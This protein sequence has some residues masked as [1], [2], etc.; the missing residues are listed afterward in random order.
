MASALKKMRE[1]DDKFERF[2]QI[3]RREDGKFYLQLSDSWKYRTFAL[4]MFGKTAYWILTFPTAKHKKWMSIAFVIAATLW[5]Q[6]KAMAAHR[7]AVNRRK[8]KDERKRVGDAK[9][10]LA[11]KLATADKDVLEKREDILKLSLSELS[12]ALKSG[13]YS[14]VEVLHAYQAKAMDCTSQVNCVIEPVNEAEEWAKQLEKDEE[15]RGLLY[16]I[17]VSIKENI[18]IKGYTS[19]LGLS[20]NIGKPANNDSALVQALKQQGAVPFVRTNVPQL[21]LSF[22]CSNP[23]YGE[24]VNPVNPDKVPG[25]SSGGE[26]ALVKMNGTPLGFG[27]DILGSARIPAHMSGVCGF[28][29]TQ[30]SGCPGLFSKDIDSIALGM[31]ALL[32]PEMFKYDKTAVPIPFREQ[33]YNGDKKLRIGY[34]DTDKLILPTTPCRRAVAIAKN[35]LEKAGH[36]LIPFDPPSPS[37]TSYVNHPTFSV[38][39]KGSFADDCQTLKTFL[40][41]EDVDPHVAVQLQAFFLPGFLKNLLSFLIRWW[42]YINEYLKAWNESELDVLICPAFAIPACTSQQSGRLAM[43]ASYSSLFNMLDFPAGCVPV[44]TVTE[45]DEEDMKTYPTNDIFDWLIKK[46]FWI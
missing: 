22:V 21:L 3:G 36:T 41:D 10:A 25:G 17:P 5:L 23:I 4:E 12:G 26:A 27:T 2:F 35:A 40:K 9:L 33:I 19:T 1:W 32:V 37:T 18:N 31:R 38:T 14:P 15:R 20:K 30:L 28:K 16:G 7:R 34:Y 42:A 46:V 44:T 11:N 29:P 39:L 24:T 6:R 13:H 43:A 45:A 8:A